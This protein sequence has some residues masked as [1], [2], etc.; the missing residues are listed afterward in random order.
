MVV[1]TDC[2]Y[3]E[4]PSTPVFKEVFAAPYLQPL[5][6]DWHVISTDIIGSTPAIEAGAYRNVMLLGTSSIVVLANAM[7]DFQFP[8]AFGGDGSVCCLP[9]NRLQTA[10]TVIEQLSLFG[11]QR[12]DLLLRFGHTSIMQVRKQGFDVLVSKFQISPENTNSIFA[13]GGIEYA[14]GILKKG[15][16]N[17]CNRSTRV[18][19]NQPDLSG[20]ECRWK[21]VRGTRE[22]FLSLLIRP[23]NTDP[24]AL[25]K[26]HKDIVSTIQHIYPRHWE[27]GPI[28]LSDLSLSLS[29]KDLKG[30]TLIRHPGAGPETQRLYLFALRMKILL[31][32]FLMRFGVSIDGFNWGSYK[33]VLIRN[34]DY[35]GYADGFYQILRGSDSQHDQ[36]LKYLD[37][38]FESKLLIYG[39]HK[40]DHAI[41]TCHVTRYADKHL[42]FLDG[43]N[44]GYTF[45]ARDLKHRLRSHHVTT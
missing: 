39:M 31:G 26:F 12:Y 9:E 19:N 4:L 10:L 22:S 38:K 35:R 41:F 21:P 29:I 3:A 24:Q 5:P 45:A 11:E 2:F 40:S 34:I 6:D 30:E 15:D 33:D 8:F 42:H 1:D 13:G 37:S 36:L 17:I 16:D 43:G 7:G 32:K 18:S 20:L 23:I 25:A 14:D 27:S 44:G 28:L